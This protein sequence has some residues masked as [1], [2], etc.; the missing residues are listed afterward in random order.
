MPCLQKVLKKLDIKQFMKRKKQT[1]ETISDKRLRIDVQPAQT[2]GAE[3]VKR[4]L[5]V[6]LHCIIS[7][8][9]G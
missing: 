8:L 9:K 7:N 1:A 5:N 3:R 2:N 4:F 6:H